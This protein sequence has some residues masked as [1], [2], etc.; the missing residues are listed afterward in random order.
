M[1]SVVQMIREKSTNIDPKI[2]FLKLL[3]PEEFQISKFGDF[4]KVG[5]CIHVTCLV[6][7]LASYN[8]IY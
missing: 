6:L 3:V 2:L 5:Y 7:R 1:I 4:R 8:Q